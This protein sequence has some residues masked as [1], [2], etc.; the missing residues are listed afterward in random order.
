[1]AG[2]TV[3]DASGRAGAAVVTL[4]W[5]GK[6]SAILVVGALFMAYD[7]ATGSWREFLLLDFPLTAVLTLAILA[8]G[9]PRRRKAGR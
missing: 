3:R 1:M 9:R 2:R 8:F 5:V 4:G 6:L 7:V